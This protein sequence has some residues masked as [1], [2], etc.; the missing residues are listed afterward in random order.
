MV[1]HSRAANW[2]LGLT[3]MQMNEI[4]DYGGVKDE[5]LRT[6]EH[7]GV[8][9]VNWVDHVE[10][11]RRREQ[12]WLDC[13]RA[14]ADAVA[15][16]A[17][18][19]KAVAPAPVRDI[20][21]GVGHTLTSLLAAAPKAPDPLKLLT[22]GLGKESQY[23]TLLTKQ[24]GEYRRLADPRDPKADLDRRA[25]SYLQANCAQCHVE[26]GGGNG[27]MNLELDAPREKTHLFGAKPQHQTFGIA[28]PLLIAP[29]DPDRS[30]LLQRVSRRGPNQM[31]PLAS[32][33]VDEEAVRM[34]RNWIAGMKKD[35]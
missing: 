17:A 19:P 31:P 20:M 5:Q 16:A 32:S 35:D 10:E 33:V 14:L 28:E 27:L 26:A 15:D 18:A 13:G 24:P 29:G 9:K 22:D 1:C 7:L 34:L 30:V 4:H 21:D 12:R 6:L 2:V 25:R 8:F 23:T 3:E 11:A